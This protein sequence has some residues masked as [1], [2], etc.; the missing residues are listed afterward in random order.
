MLSFC[1]EVADLLLP[2]SSFLSLSLLLCMHQLNV[3]DSTTMGLATDTHR[4]THTHTHTHTQTRG[5]N[6]HAFSRS[7]S[8]SLPPL[9]LLSLR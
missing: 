7:I 1:L 6:Q 8:L 3:K 9:P 2:M 5:L 4:H